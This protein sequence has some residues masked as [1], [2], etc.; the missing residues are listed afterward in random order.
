MQTNI[1]KLL[2][3]FLFFTE[4]LLSND[5]TAYEIM[6]KSDD[7]LNTYLTLKSNI[8]MQIKLEDS[9]RKRYFN[10]WRKK[11][12]NETKS[13]IRFYIPSNIK[14]TSLLTYSKKNEDN[15]QWIYLP[16]FR[17][18]K[19]IKSE[20]QHD[21]FMGS[22]FSYSDIA[23]RE[24]SK[25]R[26]TLIDE[27]EKY[28]FIRAIPKDIS[29]IYSK[30]EIIIN[31]K[32]FVPLRI[33]FYDKNNKKL[34]VLTNKKVKKIDS[35]YVVTYSIMD[36]VQKNTQTDLTISNIILNS[37]IPDSKFGIKNLKI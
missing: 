1:K 23:G 25:D 35:L 36:N 13:L 10:N 34:K 31:K 9:I 3:I 18:I 8:L 22:D 2:F 24:L 4:I 16:A 32:L 19:L 7:N 6:K 5:L 17:L 20:N 21:S 30:M 15:T 37:E 26:F 29:D 11:V 28:F 12:G 14:N 27:T 33:T